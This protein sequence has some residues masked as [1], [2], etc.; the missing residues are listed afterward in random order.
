MQS[1]DQLESKLRELK[2]LLAR[3]FH[4]TKIGY[5]GSHAL[6]TASPDSDVDLLV[7]F[8][9][10]IGWEFFTL[11]TYL[12]SVLHQRVDLV[13]PSALKDRVRSTILAQTKFI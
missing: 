7:E 12:E 4:V 1:S 8:S 10:P 11:E 6:G 9:S 2:P 13:T 5:F 3:R